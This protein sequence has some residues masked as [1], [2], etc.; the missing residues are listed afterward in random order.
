VLNANLCL[1]S[2]DP[3]TTVLLVIGRYS[4]PLGRFGAMLDRVVMGGAG[5]AT[6][7]ALVRELAS[8][9]RRDANPSGTAVAP[10]HLHQ[11]NY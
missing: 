7:E 2:A 3:V 11:K 8:S 6:A 1:R 4:P 5:R 10:G 9:V